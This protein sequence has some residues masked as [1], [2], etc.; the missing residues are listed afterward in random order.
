MTKSQTVAERTALEIA[1]EFASA[2]AEGVDERVREL[3]TADV[4]EREIN[5]AGYIELRGPDELIAER[6]EF[7]GRY[8][9]P[10]VLE[11]T[12]E[13]AGPL[14]RVINRWRHSQAGEPMLCDFYELLR[15]EDGRVAQ[16]D[17]VCSGV[18]PEPEARG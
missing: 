12:T 8:G 15:I 5:P 7:T 16:I 10:E 17:L 3:V 13:N 14:V 6:R 18:V 2:Y 9:E 11:L 4:I 1:A